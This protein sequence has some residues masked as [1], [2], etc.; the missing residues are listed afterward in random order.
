MIKDGHMTSQYVPFGTRRLA[1]DHDHSFK[2]PIDD[3]E[4]QKIKKRTP[5]FRKFRNF[6][7]LIDSFLL[8]RRV[9]SSIGYIYSLFYLLQRGK[10]RDLGG[11]Y[12]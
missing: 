8:L 12:R 4:W 10:Q 5:S 3:L 2:V 11:K 6:R 7:K 9:L 1:Y